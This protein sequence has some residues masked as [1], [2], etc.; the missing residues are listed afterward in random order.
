M[1]VCQFFFHW[2]KEK[3][4]LLQFS[5]LWC[6]PSPLSLLFHGDNLI[7]QKIL[8]TSIQKQP[9]NN[10]KRRNL[11]LTLKKKEEKLMASTKE[12]AQVDS[13]ILSIPHAIILP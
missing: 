11:W 5:R 13:L 4:D 1:Q 8:Y 2:E 10:H 9:Q 6:Y 12:R 3:D 7:D